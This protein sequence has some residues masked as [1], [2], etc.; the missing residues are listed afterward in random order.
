MQPDKKQKLIDF[1]AGK[2]G[3]LGVIAAKCIECVYDPEE[4]GTWRKQ[5][6]NCASSN[7]PLYPKRPRPLKR[8]S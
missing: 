6:E 4:K 2:P 3:N 8:R 1:H 5:V 7:C